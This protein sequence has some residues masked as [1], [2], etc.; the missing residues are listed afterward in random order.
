MS[1]S[2]IN[3]DHK[4]RLT[5]TNYAMSI[6]ESDALS[7][8]KKNKPIDK[9]NIT[10]FINRIFWNFKDDAKASI[11]TSCEHY[12]LE[13]E[14]GNNI[15]QTKF[16]KTNIENLLAEY[17]KKLESEMIHNIYDSSCSFTLRINDENLDFLVNDCSEDKF[18]G[19]Y[20]IGKYLRTLIE[21]YAFLPPAMREQI[22]YVSW[23]ENINDAINQNKQIKI[24]TENGNKWIYVKPYK[25]V[26]D[27]SA[28]YHYLIGYTIF[29][30]KTEH[31][32]AYRI[33]NLK[34]VQKP[35]L[36][37]KA[38]SNKQQEKIYKANLENELRIKGAQFMAGDSVEVQVMLTNIGQKLYNSILHL[39]PAYVTVEK[40]TTGYIYTFNCTERQIEYYF[41]NFGSEAKIIK[42]QQLVNHIAQRF[43]AAAN[44]Y[45]DDA[46]TKK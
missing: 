7:F 31:S 39:R 1:F 38:F 21:E 32:G 40:K 3:Q 33:M 5:I 44:I 13:L 23:F 36:S 11:M 25:I 41:F 17:A 34:D 24:K 19:E 8:D 10:G 2:E 15:S 43:I 28:R 27:G 20:H 29:D 9:P 4:Q 6:I 16:N 22:Y 12:R 26:L 42:P 45:S 35:R 30:D 37:R 18:Y 46:N 14:A